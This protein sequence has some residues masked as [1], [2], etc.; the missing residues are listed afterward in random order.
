MAT[1][2]ETAIKTPGVYINEIPSFPP[3][4]AQVATAIPAFLGYTRNTVLDGDSLVNKPVRI[5][6]LVEYE[7][8]FGARLE[9]FTAAVG[10]DGT[11]N[12]VTTLPAPP[13]TFYRLYYAMQMYFANGGGPCYIV[14]IGADTAT[15]AF[16]DFENGLNA[17]AKEDEPTLLVLADAHLL[18]TANEYYDAYQAALTQCENLA[19][20]FAICDVLNGQLD[21]TDTSSAA[22]NVV[23]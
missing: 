8:I 14:S 5:T 21:I 19:D 2:N 13:A 15:A 9:T 4:V 12:S 6:S 7:S 18:P 17:V 23:D 3:S 10:T 16:A 11:N 20:R 22:S 1:I